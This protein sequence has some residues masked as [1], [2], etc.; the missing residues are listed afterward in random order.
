MARRD[1]RL[2]E[3]PAEALQRG[4]LLDL[5]Y[6]AISAYISLYLVHIPPYPVGDIAKNL[7]QVRD[8][9]GDV[10]RRRPR[11]VLHTRAEP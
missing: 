3:R 4:L 2:A 8:F 10:C 7:P 1:G 6:L 5:P 9:S 11:L